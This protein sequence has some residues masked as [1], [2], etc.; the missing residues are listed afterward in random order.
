MIKMAKHEDIDSATLAHLEALEPMLQPDFR[1]A[2][3]RNEE[4]VKD[5]LGSEIVLRYYYQKGQAAYRL[6]FD[7]ELKRALRELK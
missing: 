6:R 4:E 7:E 2:I 3:K 1:E 5:L